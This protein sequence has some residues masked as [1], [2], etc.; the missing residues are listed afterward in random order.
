MLLSGSQWLKN[1]RSL[2][3]KIKAQVQLYLGAESRELKSYKQNY[4][5]DIKR[6]WKLSS[7][8]S[9]VMA[10]RDSEVVLGGDFHP[11]AQAQRA[12]LRILRAIPKD[13]K[14]TI[15]LECLSY[16]SNAS[17]KRYLT[18]KIDEKK[19]LKLVKW[20]KNWGFPWEN[21]KP[22]F[23]FAQKNAVEIV[24]LSPDLSKPTNLKKRDQFAAEVIQK[25]LVKNKNS[26]IYAVIGDLHIV[27]SHLPRLILKSHSKNTKILSVFF[28]PEKVY[29]DLAKKKQES[30]AEVVRFNQ[31][32]FAYMVS[33]PWV[34]WQS[35]LLFLEKRYDTYIDPDDD[36]E[37]TVDYTD[38]IAQL[39]KLLAEDFKLKIKADHIAVYSS[40]DRENITENVTDQT[41]LKLIENDMSF[42]MP[43]EGF[44]YLSRATVNHA[45]SLAGLYVHGKLCKIDRVLWN[46]P[47][48][49][50]K[51]IWQQAIAFFLSKTVNPKRKAVSVEALKRQLEVFSPKDKG[52][53]ALLLAINHKMNEIFSLYG[54]SH[55]QL[56]FRPK[57]KFSYF[58][59]AYFLG[60]MLGDKIY[61]LFAAERISQKD[62]I[63]WLKKDISS[64]DFINFYFQVLKQL[65]RIESEFLNYDRDDNVVL[66]QKR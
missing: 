46:M 35:Y 44:F 50:L 22:L 65:D 29:F 59:A 7:F 12:H 54:K 36:D 53:E 51:L 60:E 2:T 15:A 40:D 9:L 18:Q 61:Q 1:R 13:K 37:F 33:P 41:L 56:D 21:Y 63:L 19:F 32:E 23:D 10:I 25:Q 30:Q 20:E 17:I 49:F 24:G 28:N 3:D 38:H 26:I 47:E 11:Y 58:R 55:D 5:A 27:R 52:R 34:K 31:N 39:V 8:E 6:P 66:Q 42:Y 62:I 43:R 4:H 14:I 57:D 48:D 16:S 64:L 45:A